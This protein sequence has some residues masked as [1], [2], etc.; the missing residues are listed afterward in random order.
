MPEPTT[1][2][3]TAPT[4][5]PNRV[6]LREGQISEL[7]VIAPLKPGGA[8]RLRAILASTGGHFQLADKVGTVHDMRFVF[9]DNDTRLLFATAYDGDWDHYINDFATLIPDAMDMLFSEVA[10]WPG[11][12]SPQVKD[13][14]AKYQVTASAWYVAYPDATVSTVRRGLRALSALDN[15][16]DAASK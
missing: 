1:P 15:L 14:I 10:D 7:T 8:A 12:R 3:P 11:I 6:G 5:P 9:I 16:L 4:T 2:A 13:V